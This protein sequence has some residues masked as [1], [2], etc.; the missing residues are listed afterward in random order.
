MTPTWIEPDVRV[1]HRG[2]REFGTVI[3]VEHQATGE[4]VVDFDGD[5]P[6]TVSAVLLTPASDAPGVIGRDT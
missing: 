1:W 3:T 6:L 5:G 4:C 2:R